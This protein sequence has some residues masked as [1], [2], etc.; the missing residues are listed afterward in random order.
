MTVAGTT[1]ETGPG[2]TE[3]FLVHYCDA[4]IQ[5]ECLRRFDHLIAGDLDAN[6]RD[7]LVFNRSVAGI[8]S[9]SNGTT[10]TNASSQPLAG[11]GRRR[12]Q[13]QRP[14][15]PFGRLRRRWALGAL[16]QRHMDQDPHHV[17]VGDH[18]RPPRQQ[19]QRGSCGR[20]RRRAASGARFNNSTW[21]KLHAGAPLGLSAGDLDG[22]SI[23]DLLV[24]FGTGGLWGR[25]NNA[26]WLKLHNDSPDDFLTARLD[27]NAKKE[28]V[29]DFGASGLWARFN[30]AT[31]TKLHVGDP[32]DLAAGDL[33]GNGVEDLLVNFGASGL[34][35]RVTTTPRGSSS[36]APRRTPSSRPISTTAARRRRWPI[37]APADS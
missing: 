35:G 32:V 34:S 29:V 9:L 5:G 26:T 31:W 3:P 23:D 19:C 21:T 37:S 4:A 6:P 13:R 30:N 1:P 16:R 7:D 8:F 11:A 28:A 2:E 12:F 14:R 15:R 10:W 22:N 36:I 27:N 25:Y 20:F 18:D 33:D 17:A 24:D